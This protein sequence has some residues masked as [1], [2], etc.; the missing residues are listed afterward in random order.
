[1]ISAKKRSVNNFCDSIFPAN[2]IYSW[3][4]YGFSVNI[5]AFPVH[6]GST[7]S[8][9]LSTPHWRHGTIRWWFLPLLCMRS[10]SYSKGQTQKKKNQTED[11]RASCILTSLVMASLIGGVVMFIV[12]FYSPYSFVDFWT[13]FLLHSP[14]FIC[15]SEFFPLDS[16][17]PPSFLSNSG[18]S[19][20]INLCLDCCLSA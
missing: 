9:L 20:V 3:I 12:L 19:A 18:S 1:M 11:R 15:P 2:V 6:S 13:I 14:I 16:W 8:F 10:C 5:S 7:H 17:L 4:L